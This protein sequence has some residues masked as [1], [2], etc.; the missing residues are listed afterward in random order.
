[1]ILIG[2][3][4]SKKNLDTFWIAFKEYIQNSSMVACNIFNSKH[5]PWLEYA[6]VLCGIW[7]QGQCLPTSTY[8]CLEPAS[9]ASLRTR[10][11]VTVKRFSPCPVTME[12]AAPSAFLSSYQWVV[13]TLVM[14]TVSLMLISYSNEIKSGAC[15]SLLILFSVCWGRYFRSGLKLLIILSGK[16]KHSLSM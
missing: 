9:R 4:L 16:R 15:F 10:L 14:K 1:M 2:G 12:K 3:A 8:C 5:C 6:N 11:F 7:S 13:S